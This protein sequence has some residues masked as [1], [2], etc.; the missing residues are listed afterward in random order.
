[1]VDEDVRDILGF[2]PSEILERT[3]DALADRNSKDL[4]AT[5][6]IVV[7]Q[8]LHLQQ[9]VREFIGRIRDL[10][11]MKLG[12]A[13]K[14]LGSDEDKRGLAARA[15]RF[16]E[17]DLIRCFDLLLKLDTDLRAT[18]QPRFHLEIAFIK[19]AK[20]GHI[21]DIEE[22]IRELRDTPEAARPGGPASP[23]PA[24]PKQASQAKPVQPLQEPSKL[25]QPLQEPS[26]LKMSGTEP[27]AAPAG[28]AGAFH[29]RVEDKS[30]ATGIY[31]Q[32]ADRIERDGDGVSITVGNPTTMAM[33]ESREHKAVLDASAS[34]LVGKPVSVSLIMKELQPKSGANLEN[35]R[36]EPL[37]QRFLDVF[38]GDLAQVKPS[39]G[40]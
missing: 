38:R 23:P 8:G 35:A 12:L 24:P 32:R 14:I 36:N 19:L 39:K 1:V 37:V 9:Y 16:S 17:Q 3:L 22:V 18:S 5:V 34:E 10:L 15:E 6:G 31:L 29:T 25:K 40:E 4:L 28:F 30:E 2:I 20:I 21:R 13:E 33:L 26:K 7:D 11:V 27:V